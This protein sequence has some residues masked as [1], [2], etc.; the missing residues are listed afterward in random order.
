MNQF[1]ALTVK[2]IKALVNE[3]EHA[4]INGVPEKD[5]RKWYLLEFTHWILGEILEGRNPLPD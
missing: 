3:F 2:Q 1:D 5:T 4:N